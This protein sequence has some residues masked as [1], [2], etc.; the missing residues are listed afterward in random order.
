M[1]GRWA[2]LINVAYRD[3]LTWANP[4]HRVLEE[5]ALV[6]MLGQTPVELGMT[7]HEAGIFAALGRDAVY[8]RLFPQA[9]PEVNGEQL[10]RTALVSGGQHRP[11]RRHA[12]DRKCRQ[13]PRR[14][15]GTSP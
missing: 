4:N 10:G 15:C 5:Q 14:R 9:F 6:P 12:E 13:V 8:Q 7:G 1:T 3:T 2:A 11:A